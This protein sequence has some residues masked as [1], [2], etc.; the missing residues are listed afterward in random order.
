MFYRCF[1]IGNDGRYAGEIDCQKIRGYRF[2]GLPGVIR[3]V[4]SIT[5]W[6][7]YDSLMQAHVINLLS[8]ILATCHGFAAA[9]KLQI[10]TPIWLTAA[11]P[12]ESDPFSACIS[13]LIINIASF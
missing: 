4:G 5:V 9:S 13:R 2:G 7:Y 6:V 8:L 3:G 12:F 10:S 1:K 11:S